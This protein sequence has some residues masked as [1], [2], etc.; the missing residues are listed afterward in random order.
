MMKR[1]LAVA[2]AL[3][4][5][6]ASA[7]A[8]TRTLT[9]IQEGQPEEV[10]ETLYVSDL[11]FSFWYNA[12]MLTVSEEEYDEGR[13]VLLEPI[14]CDT[15]VYLELMEYAVVGDDYLEDNTVETSEY[16]EQTTA[17]GA[18]LY[19]VWLRGYGVFSGNYLLTWQGETLGVATRWPDE[20][21]EGYGFWLMRA[22]HSV[23][24]DAQPPL[25]LC[26]AEEYE[27]DLSAC[28]PFALPGEEPQ[29]SLV[30]TALQPITDVQ[31][32]A[33]EMEGISDEGI[34]EYS[35]QL[36]Y[37]LPEL[38]PEQ[39]LLLT[40]SFTGEQPGC[41][42]RYVDSDGQEQRFTVEMSGED[43]SAQLYAY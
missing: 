32:L 37:T 28:L 27:G 8:E 11:G 18:L 17:A 24:F 13:S 14:D 29:A 42:I 33:V 21:A 9:V 20:M 6:T 26:W 19:G 43:G 7:C 41:G 35:E 16:E 12:E 23:R 15:P 30:L 34:P 40:L 31:L 3:L 36:L 22:L 2:L 10:T 39:P 25:A 1:I 4:L 38:T 5:L